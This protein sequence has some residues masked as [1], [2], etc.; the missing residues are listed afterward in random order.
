[1][2]NNLFGNMVQKNVINLLTKFFRF[3]NLY[4]LEGKAKV[5]EY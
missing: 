2:S 1:M 4:R 3:L 5:R